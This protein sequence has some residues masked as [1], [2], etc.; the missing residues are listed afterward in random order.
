M[1]NDCKYSY[2]TLLI[3]TD[4]NPRVRDTLIEN[5]IVYYGQLIIHDVDYFLSFK[6]FGKKSF[7]ELRSFLKKAN[8]TNDE[9]APG[10]WPFCFGE[11][12]KQLEEEIAWRAKNVQRAINKYKEVTI[13]YAPDINLY[14]K[15]VELEESVTSV[16]DQ[17]KQLYL[18]KETNNDD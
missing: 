10:N 1:M 8:N 11:R 6:K 4:L 13:K 14:Y 7:L 18:K 2:D 16:T 15:I 3:E 17:Y 9:D 12:A 5:G